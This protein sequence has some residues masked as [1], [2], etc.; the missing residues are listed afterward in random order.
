MICSFL[1]LLSILFT[2][3]APGQPITSTKKNNPHLHGVQG[4][5]GVGAGALGLVFAHHLVEFLLGFRCF[6]GNIAG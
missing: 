6:S 5:K 1:E 3:R 2:P 4:A